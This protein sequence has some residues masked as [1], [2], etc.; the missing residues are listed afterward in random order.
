MA[1]REDTRTFPG[2]SHL[3]FQHPLDVIDGQRGAVRVLNVLYM[4]DVTE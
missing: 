2:L 3:A 1:L 4:I